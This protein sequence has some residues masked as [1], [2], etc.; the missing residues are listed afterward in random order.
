MKFTL[1]FILIILAV[2]SS[3]GFGYV[4]ISYAETLERSDVVAITR[5]SATEVIEVKSLPASLG[6]SEERAVEWVRTTLDVL[7][8]VKGHRVPAQ[9]ALLHKRFKPGV[10]AEPGGFVNFES[11]E[12]KPTFLVF[13]RRESTYGHD[14]VPTTGHIFAFQSVIRMEDGGAIGN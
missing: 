12:S 7:A 5:V 14:F 1:A 4:P 13:L 8:V 3:L 10:A 9:I 6:A 11:A 2:R